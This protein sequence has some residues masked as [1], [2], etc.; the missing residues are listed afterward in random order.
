ME[1]REGGREGGNPSYSLN[2]NY[3]MSSANNTNCMYKMNNP[4]P[5]T[6]PCR[7]RYETPSGLGEKSHILTN[8]FRN[9]FLF[10][11]MHAVCF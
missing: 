9:P 1:G 7:I 5:R 4:G 2:I 11:T 6:E 10:K 3:N 8:C